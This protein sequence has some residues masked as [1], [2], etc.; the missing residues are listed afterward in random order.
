MPIF[1]LAVLLAVKEAMLTIQ[2][3]LRPATT[4]DGAFKKF[5]GDPNWD[6][7]S[8]N[9]VIEDIAND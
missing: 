6:E 5:A 4:P 9:G 1:Q 8:G 7:G 2:I 3:L